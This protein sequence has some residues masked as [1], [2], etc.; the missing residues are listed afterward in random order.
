M[1]EL[2]LPL[3]FFPAVVEALRQG[4]WREAKNPKAYL[5]T[6]AGREA[7]KLRLQEN[8]PFEMELVSPRTRADGSTVGYEETIEELI[9]NSGNP[10]VS[11]GADGVWRRGGAE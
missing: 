3:G 2:A 8:I 9:H 5:K 10:G 4:R 7:V 6:V 11:R 1:D